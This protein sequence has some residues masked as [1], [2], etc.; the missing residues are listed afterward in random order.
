MLG[1]SNFNEN[2]K[3]YKTFFNMLP[4]AAIVHDGKKVLFTNNETVKILKA[5]NQAQILNIHPLRVVHTDYKVIVKERMKTMLKEG[6]RVEK[7]EEKFVRFDGEIIDVEV[8]AEPFIYKNKKVVQLI[9]QDIT[10]KKKILK[11]I[12]ES[13]QK[14]SF[15]IQHTPLGVISWD[16]NF[17]VVS[18]NPAAKK[19]FG[20]SK[21]EAAGK[22]AFDLIVPKEERAYVERVW[23]RLIEQKKFVRGIN[24]NITKANQRIYCQWHNTVL[25]NEENNVIGVTSIVHD[26]TREKNS[27]I[28][29]RKAKKEA[30]KATQLKDKFVSLVAHD[31]KN[32]IHPI[33]LVFDLIKNTENIKEIKDF[34]ETGIFS[35]G[36]M[37][38]LINDILKLTRIHLG[39]IN[40]ELSIFNAH[41]FIEAIIKI[42]DEQ[43]NKK[44]IQII[45]KID[46]DLEI[47]A[48]ISL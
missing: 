48:D 37:I 7:K 10:E 41:S 27:E 25:L 43:A 23:N 26:I 18:W 29:L 11:D 19:I 2:I 45:N 12:R 5:K 31:L 22:N 16:I 13:E 28:K 44:G 1:E 47:Y 34:A 46:R 35:C 39:K 17:N 36:E 21:E 33:M 38:H 3:L 40:P 4:V 20:Y 14:L 42:F 6:R 9:F 8:S 32:K 15:H 24:E 30:E